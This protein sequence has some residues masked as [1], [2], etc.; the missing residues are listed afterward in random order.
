MGEEQQTQS[1]APSHLDGRDLGNIAA[2]VLFA[3]AMLL[4]QHLLLVGWSI[5]AVLVCIALPATVAIFLAWPYSAGN[6]GTRTA[7]TLV[8][9]GSKTRL[10]RAAARA[11]YWIVAGI[12]ACVTLWIA[13]TCLETTGIATPGQRAAFLMFAIPAGVLTMAAFEPSSKQQ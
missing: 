5:P 6:R 10:A 13:L 1:A 9:V 12:T 8:R 3:G 2:T 11:H 7:K 4:L